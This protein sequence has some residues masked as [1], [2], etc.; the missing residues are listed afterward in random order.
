MDKDEIARQIREQLLAQRFP[1][2]MEVSPHHTVG[3]AERE[4]RRLRR[5]RGPVSEDQ[6]LHLPTEH[7]FVY[8]SDS[9]AE[10]LSRTV[11]VVTDEQGEIKYVI[12]SK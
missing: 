10:G 11:V 2:L 4:L 12:D 8:R 1:D 3:P 6:S 5:S 7:R 9:G